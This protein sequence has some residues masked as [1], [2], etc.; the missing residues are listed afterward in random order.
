MSCAIDQAFT[1][2]AISLGRGG[3][4]I[5]ATRRDDSAL[6]MYLGGRAG[7]AVKEALCK[8]TV[9]TLRREARKPGSVFWRRGGRRILASS[10]V[11]P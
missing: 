7:S 2:Q 9:S 3:A 6:P 4:I 1:C 8:F 10:A 11:V 5:Q